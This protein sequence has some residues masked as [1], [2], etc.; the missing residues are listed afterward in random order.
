M[1]PKPFFLNNL[2][3]QNRIKLTI[4]L[5]I[6]ELNESYQKLFIINFTKLPKHKTINLKNYIITVNDDFNISFNRIILPPNNQL[7]TI[8]KQQI[9]FQRMVKVVIQL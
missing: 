8:Y 3:T 7:S 6:I 1:V 2:N 5:Q 4:V 9:A